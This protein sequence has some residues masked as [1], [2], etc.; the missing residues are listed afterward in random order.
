ME[1]KDIKQTFFAFRNGMLADTLRNMGYPY[2][3]IFGLNVPQLASIARDLGEN[4]ALADQ[5]WSDRDVRESRLL[6]C[7]L[8]PKDISKEKAMEL[9][10][11]VQTT[12]EADMLCFRLLK[13]LPFASEIV[14]E[15]AGSDSDLV[16]Y[17]SK[18]LLRHL[19]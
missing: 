12:E 4:T 8:F 14:E 13:H 16:R 9:V 15:T 19:S 5:L 6:A 17:L 3:M 1:I 10:K 7:Y 2:R 11:D 18:M